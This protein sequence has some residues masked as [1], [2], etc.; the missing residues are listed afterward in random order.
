MYVAPAHFFQCP[1][2]HPAISKSITDAPLDIQAPVIDV[3]VKGKGKRKIYT[4]GYSGGERSGKK[5]LF[6]AANPPTMTLTL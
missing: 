2:H 1:T 4:D 3:N 5:A 6:D